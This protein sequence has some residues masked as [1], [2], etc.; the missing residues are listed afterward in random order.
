MALSTKTKRR[1]Q[2]ALTRVNLAT[3]M[4]AAMNSSAPIS[5]KLKRAILAALAGKAAADEVV[6][7]LQSGAASLSA[8]TKARIT[9]AMA[10][11]AA[12]NELISELES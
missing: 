3:E 4:E 6:S 1:L 2:V 11:K 12:A 8:K 5:L 10:N 7:V 9:L